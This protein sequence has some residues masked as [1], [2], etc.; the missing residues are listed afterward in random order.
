MHRALSTS[1]ALLRAS[2]LYEVQLFQAVERR[3]DL[4]PRTEGNGSVDYLK[5]VAH[6]SLELPCEFPMG[7]IGPKSKTSL[8]S[9]PLSEP[10]LMGPA[11][12]APV[13]SLHAYG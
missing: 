2:V 6:S 3:E 13:N 12:P 8:S 4:A 11:Q 10:A 1:A 5:L 9:H 7:S